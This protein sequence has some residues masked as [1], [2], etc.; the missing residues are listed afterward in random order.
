MGA[1]RASRSRSAAW[2]AFVSLVSAFAGC[3][4]E[5][6]SAYVSFNIPPDSECIFAPASMLFTSSGSLDLGFEGSEI[7]GKKSYFLHLL[8]NSNLKSNARDST[9]R[10]EPN[11][12]Q[13][14]E[15]D[16][17]LMDN[18][19]ATLDFK[20]AKFPNPFRVQTNNSL[21]PTTSRDP[22]M[23]VVA[24]EAIPSAY[25]PKLDQFVDKTMLIEVQI[26]GS[27]TGDVDID[28]RPFV[29]PVAIC[30]GC[31]TVCLDTLEGGDLS[32]VYGDQ[33]ADNSGHDGRP[34]VDDCP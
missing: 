14:T 12:L 32:T 30:R 19:K 16:V 9:G 10:A 22:T 27:T 23:G 3:A 7:C 17:R 2:L 24:V 21:R 18:N 4:P 33:C 34:C 13:I 1:V 28:F 25:A 20:D 31:N 6:S 26:Y 8:V 15:A 5:G 11:V 29:Y